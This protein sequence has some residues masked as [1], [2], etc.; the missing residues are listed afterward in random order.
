MAFL[1]SVAT[2]TAAI[3]STSSSSSFPSSSRSPKTL[4]VSFP[5]T[6]QSSDPNRFSLFK[7]LANPPSALHMDASTLQH[8]TDAVLPDLLTEYMVDMKCEG[9]VNAV[10]NKLQTIPGVK[11]VEVDLSNQVVRILGSTPVKAMTE[12]L[13]QTGRKAR[14][15]GQGMPED[16]AISAAVSEFKGP[17]IFGVVRL[18]QVNMELARIEANFSGLSP[19]KHGW[20]IN[21][22]GDL[23]RGA[24][25]T[26][27][28]FHPT[29]EENKKEP[30]GDLGTLDA[31]E[32][33]E[34]FFSGVKEKLR[35]A[36][37]IGRSVVVYATEDK[38]ED[39]IAAAVIARSAG[40]GENY[41]KLCT[42]DGTTIWEASDRDFVTSKV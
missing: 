34:A 42:C 26:G 20:S 9:C 30:L 13:E 12:A 4:N 28:V 25:S 10:K 2:T 7:S 31:N 22:F 39:G 18:A 6:S 29:N 35:V 24:A 21:E 17:D 14:L 8:K 36:D 5:S 41:K 16:F 32:K 19:G 40:V 23:T 37:L 3:V 38:T 1:R 11:N 27:K 33:G 15:I